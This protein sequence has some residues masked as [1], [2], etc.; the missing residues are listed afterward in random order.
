MYTQVK[1]YRRRE[2][3]RQVNKLKEKKVFLSET[4]LSFF[5]SCIDSFTA[6]E[7]VCTGCNLVRCCLHC[8]FMGKKSPIK[9]EKSA[10]QPSHLSYE[11]AFLHT[12]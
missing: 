1:S 9:Y 10:Y 8:V 3:K 6:S 11:T 5:F 12:L 2:L 7:W 4:P